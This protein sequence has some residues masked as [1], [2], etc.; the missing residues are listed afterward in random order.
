M[1]QA[2]AAHIATVIIGVIVGLTNLSGNILDVAL[3]FVVPAWIH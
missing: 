2:S 1:I 3:W